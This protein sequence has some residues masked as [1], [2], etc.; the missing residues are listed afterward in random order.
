MTDRNMRE[1]ATNRKSS[2]LIKS[3]ICSSVTW[4]SRDCKPKVFFIQS[5]FA[6]FIDL[7]PG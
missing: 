7:K 4:T 3:C 6:G 1:F 2:I 5:G